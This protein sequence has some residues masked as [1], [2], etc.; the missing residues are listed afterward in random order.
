MASFRYTVDT[1]PMADEIRSVSKHVNA[2]TGA[3]VAMQ[4]AV[5]LAEERAAQHVCN[6]L[7]RGFYSLIHS[8]ISQKMAKLQSDVDSHFMQLGQQKK[9]LLGIKN[10]MER[11]YRM[12]AS[13]Y[14]KLFNELNSN[15]KHRIFEL[16]KP[17]IHFAV[18]DIDKVSNRPKYLTATVPVSQLESLASSQRIVASGI[19]SICIEVMHSMKGFLSEMNKQ[20]KL[21]N[22]VLISGNVN[23]DATKYHIPVVLC[24]CSRENGAYTMEV[25]MPDMSFD[26]TTRLSIRNSA[27]GARDK[28]IWDVASR[29]N[30]EIQTEFAR[31]L[32]ASAK[33]KRVNELAES[34]FNSASFQSIAK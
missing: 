24:E 9:A 13:K 27:L 19:K 17:T 5:I 10:R 2:T 14:T 34:M 18:K 21:I 8:Q 7:N 32:S 3:I 28:V 15:L 1:K 11:D 22:Q 33:S 31:L 20:K 29:P 16:D 26:K 30:R 23:V 6:N 4:A 25:T 12:I